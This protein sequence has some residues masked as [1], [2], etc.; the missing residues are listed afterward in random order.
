MSRAGRAE[1]PKLRAL[2]VLS[3]ALDIGRRGLTG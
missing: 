1:E 2:L 3:G